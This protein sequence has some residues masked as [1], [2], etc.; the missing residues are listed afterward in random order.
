MQKLISDYVVGLVDGEGSFSVYVRDLS[1]S[2]EAKRRT[3]IEPK[4]F[5]KLIEVD[6]KILYCLKEFFRCGHVF[7]QKD[8]RPNHK[9]CYRFEIANRRDLNN[10]LIP[11]FKKHPLKLVS[12]KKDFQLFCKI[13]EH[14]NLGEHLTDNGLRKLYQI[15]RKMH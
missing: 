15:K 13:M 7:F 6:K 14:I 9:N 5:L 12:K 8:N 11:F 4:F 3:R 10:K 1:Q 2:K